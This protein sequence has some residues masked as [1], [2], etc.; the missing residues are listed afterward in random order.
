MGL[1]CIGLD[2]GSPHA[3]R[4]RPRRAMGA[5]RGLCGMN[6]AEDK[7]TIQPMASSRP[8]DLPVHPAWIAIKVRWQLSG[9]PVGRDAL[10]GL[11][12]DLHS[13]MPY[14]RVRAASRREAVRAR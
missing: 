3:L 13:E 2:A 5:D 7:T 12:A 11:V 1:G 4:E 9:P 8:A 10:A 6:Q 14:D